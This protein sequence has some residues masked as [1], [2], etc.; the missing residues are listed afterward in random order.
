MCVL[1]VLS[2][3]RVRVILAFGSKLPAGV[4]KP[5]RVPCLGRSRRN[6]GLG[7]KKAGTDRFPGT[8]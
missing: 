6:L 7:Q 3:L 5:T 1:V 2:L 4:G 8:G